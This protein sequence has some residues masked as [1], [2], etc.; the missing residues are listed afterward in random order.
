MVADAARAVSENQGISVDLSK[1]PDTDPATRRLMRQGDTMGC[2]YIESPGMRS[3]LKKLKADTFPIVVAASSVIRPGPSDSGMSRSFV[4]RHLGKEK[5]VLPHPSLEFLNETYGVMIYQEDVM[6][7]L[8][9]VAGMTL[10]EADLMR[11]SMSFKGDAKEFL[12]MQDRFLAGARDAMASRPRP[13]SRARGDRGAVAAGQQLRRLRLLQ[14]PLGQLRGALVPGRLA[15]GPP[16]G[17]VHGRG[18]E[19]RRRLLQRVGLPRGDAP[20]GPGDPAAGHQP[21][22]GRVSPARSGRCGSGCSRST[23]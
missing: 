19:Q 4:L 12:A 8:S 14:G 16:P 6:R 18:H 9:A 2:F 15:E 20:P 22:P 5:P 21:Q 17:R 13:R 1:L 11:R 23:A 3:L 7:T 10:A